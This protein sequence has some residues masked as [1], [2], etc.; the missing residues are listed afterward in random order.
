MVVAVGGPG[1]CLCARQCREN[2]WVVVMVMGVMYSSDSVTL[3]LLLLYCTEGTLATCNKPC[4]APVL[5]C[6]AL[7]VA[8]FAS[9]GGKVKH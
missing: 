7:F 9:S 5:F 3:L 2:G 6:S 4:V 8:L 1:E